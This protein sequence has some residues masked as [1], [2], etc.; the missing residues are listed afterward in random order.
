[1]KVLGQHVLIEQQLIEKK[2]AIIKANGSSQELKYDVT[3][4]VIQVGKDVKE[5]AI[6]PGVKPIFRNH[7]Q[8]EGIKVVEKK[9]EKEILH[10]L[11]HEGDIIALDD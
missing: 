5:K 1:M 4:K 6:M 10:V 8:F 7:V 3:F 9:K 11:V 2:S